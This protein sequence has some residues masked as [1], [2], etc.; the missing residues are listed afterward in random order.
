MGLVPRRRRHNPTTRPTLSGT[1]SNRAPVGTDGVM[2]TFGLK[3]MAELRSPRTLVEHARAAQDEGFDFVAISDHF[4]PWLP[5]HH[6]SGFAWS[7]LGAVAVG[8][9]RLAL[10][11]GVTCPIGRYHPAIVAQAAAT[12]ATLSDRPFTLAVGTGERLNE[13]ITGAP[14]PAIDQRLAMLRDAITIIRA[15]WTG[16]WT[17]LRLEH[18]TV[19]DARLFDLPEQPPGLVVAV[20]GEDSRQQATALAARRI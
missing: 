7:V 4:H 18:F 1:V 19:E 5:E 16:E 13:H 2:T 10:A 20:S 17:T 6:H 8:Q 15:L 14:F 11:T 9:P 12:V 3:L